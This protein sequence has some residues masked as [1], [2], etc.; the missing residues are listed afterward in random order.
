MTRSTHSHAAGF[1][2]HG[3]GCVLLIPR[4]AVASWSCRKLTTMLPTT[5]APATEHMT[6]CSRQVAQ[7][8]SNRNMVI[9][10]VFTTHP[11]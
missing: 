10:R 3:V 8:L 1:A 4:A 2:W 5:I 9:V 7:P 6:G 11:C